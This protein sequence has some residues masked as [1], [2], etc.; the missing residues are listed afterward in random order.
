MASSQRSAEPAHT[1]ALLDGSLAAGDSM[2]AVVKP[3]AAPSAA[4]RK[5]RVVLISTRASSARSADRKTSQGLGCSEPPGRVVAPHV[6]I[7]ATVSIC[8]HTMFVSAVE[9]AWRSAPVL[10][11]SSDP[12]RSATQPGTKPSTQPAVKL[13]PMPPPTQRSPISEHM[14]SPTVEHHSD[15][16]ILR[17]G[18]PAMVALV[19]A[20]PHAPESRRPIPKTASPDTMREAEFIWASLRSRAQNSKPLCLVNR[21]ALQLLAGWTG[22]EP[23]ASSVTG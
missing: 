17:A 13:S 7:A 10:P 15:S 9:H 16:V 20:E 2:Q 14:R 12:S 6:S 3:S 21:R 8:S 1:V 4:R 18:S 19:P 23:A 22:L 5:M 11:V